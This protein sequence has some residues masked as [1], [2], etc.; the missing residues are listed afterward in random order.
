LTEHKQGNLLILTGTRGAGK[1]TLIGQLILA[2]R[3]RGVALT[4]LSSPAVFEEDQKTGIAAVDL[5]TDETRHLAVY[6]PQPKD[7]A[8]QH[9]PLNWAFDPAVITW[10]NQVFAQAVP[11]EVLVVD[12]IGP[13]ELQRGQGWSGAILALD[14]RQYHLAILVMRPELLAES[15]QRWPWAEVME[16]SQ[17]DQVSARKQAI[18]ERYFS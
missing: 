10:G 15:L 16:V 7:P 12:E 5:A 4:G 17:G 13:L 14:S 11:T 8:A 6:A 2:F 9:R 18:L 3:Q 1:T